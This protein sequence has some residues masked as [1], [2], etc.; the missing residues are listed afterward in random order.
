MISLQMGRKASGRRLRPSFGSLRGPPGNAKTLF[1]VA[2]H[3]FAIETP[4]ALGTDVVLE[5]MS[6]FDPRTKQRS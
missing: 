1:A 6:E 5:C 4:H 2:R 3:Q